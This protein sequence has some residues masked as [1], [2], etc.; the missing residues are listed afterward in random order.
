MLATLLPAIF[1]PAQ[2][3]QGNQ[4]RTPPL[5]HIAHSPTANAPLPQRRA[6]P[7]L[8]ALGVSPRNVSEAEGQGGRP[9][10][11]CFPVD[12]ETMSRGSEQKPHCP[13]SVW[14]DHNTYRVPAAQ[15][16]CR[17]EPC[18]AGTPAGLGWLA[19]ASSAPGKAVCP[20]LVSCCQQATLVTT[21]CSKRSSPQR[22][23]DK[24][25]L[26]VPCSGSFLQSRI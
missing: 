10:L 15:G 11:C 21:S 16:R 6:S 4:R 7:L 22:L 26:G 14:E 23:L 12:E 19:A 3:T 17:L 1:I 25:V 20:G 5:T 2:S 13:G 8:R 9:G 24:H 18:A